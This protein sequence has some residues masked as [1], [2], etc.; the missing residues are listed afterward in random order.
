MHQRSKVKCINHWER[1][2]SKGPL[3][4]RSPLL[5]ISKKVISNCKINKCSPSNFEAGNIKIFMMLM[6][7]ES[8]DDSRDRQ[9]FW[10]DTSK[11]ISGFKASNSLAPIKFSPVRW[12]FVDLELE[13]LYSILVLKKTRTGFRKCSGNQKFYRKGILDSPTDSPCSMDHAP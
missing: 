1:I 12:M 7:H 2:I 10:K 8:W 6:S 4:Q 5:Q 9:Y 3:I 11:W 13:T